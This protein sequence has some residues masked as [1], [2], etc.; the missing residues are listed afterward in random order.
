METEVLGGKPSYTHRC[1]PC[2]KA[3]IV[4]IWAVLRRN[5]NLEICAKKLPLIDTQWGL[6]LSLSFALTSWK[7]K[8]LSPLKSARYCLLWCDRQA[9]FH[10]L[11]W[12]F[13]AG[14]KSFYRALESESH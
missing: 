10:G 9:N 7:S 12:C 2:H 14:S 1:R 8:V 4:A 13:A 5:Q 11:F 3:A 6:L